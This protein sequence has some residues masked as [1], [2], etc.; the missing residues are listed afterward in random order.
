MLFVLFTKSSMKTH[1]RDQKNVVSFGCS[2]SILFFLDCWKI[3][4]FF[5]LKQTR[6]ITTIL[7]TAYSTTVCATTPLQSTGKEV[8]IFST[9]FVKLCPF[10]YRISSKCE[11]E[12]PNG[13]QKR[14]LSQLTQMFTWFINT[15]V[16]Q[17]GART[18][19]PP[20]PWSDQ[21]IG[22]PSHPPDKTRQ[23]QDTQ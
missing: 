4:Y 8:I 2:Y 17:L 15:R 11:K 7:L 23:G 18:G 5:D 16:P 22:T 1:S 19:V 13:S 6:W 14:P 3:S 10:F 21:D 12:S 20:P 9:L